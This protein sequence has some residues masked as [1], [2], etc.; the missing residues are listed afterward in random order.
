MSRSNGRNGDE[1]RPM[2]LTAGVN[3][4]AEG[5][6]FIEVGET[7]V[8][9]T[10]TV[11]ERVPPFMK[12]QGK[13]WVTAEYSMLPRATHS[14]NQREAA[15]GKL[16]GRTM[17]IQRLIG[18]ALR[19]VVN[20]QALGERT[21]TLDCDV[22]QADGGTRTTSITGSFVALA[23]AVNKI[24]VQHKL[25]VFP[26][27]DFLA[28]VSVGVVGEKALLDLNYEEDSKAKVDMNLVMTGSGKYVELQ[29][30]GEESPFDRQE[31]DQLLSLGEQGILQ[32]IERQKE[33]LGPIADKIGAGRTGAGA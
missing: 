8:I 1:L 27:T 12:G 13:G 23:I 22:I 7:K 15:R 26:I 17:E 9:C 29:G 28:S 20:L 32:M 21:I 10:A 2:K 25:P 4:Y 3:K 30:T 11:E 5:S 14:R 24:A 6:V 16:T 19:S 31:L 33:V 18:R